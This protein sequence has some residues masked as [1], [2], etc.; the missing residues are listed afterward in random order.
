[1]PTRL[2]PPYHDSDCYAELDAVLIDD[3]PE[4]PIDDLLEEPFVEP[5]TAI[6]VTCP[7]CGRPL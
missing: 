7:T 2:P 1:M 6:V 3:E 5:V 4:I